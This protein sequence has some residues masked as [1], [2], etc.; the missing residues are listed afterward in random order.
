MVGYG[1]LTGY[2]SVSGFSWEAAL[3]F[4][5]FPF[6][7]PFFS[8]ILRK[9]KKRQDFS[10]QFGARAGGEGLV[11]LVAGGK[12]GIHYITY[13]PEGFLRFLFL[14]CFSCAGGFCTCM[15]VCMYVCTTAFFFLF[16]PFSL[17]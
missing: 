9:G 8:R 7:L 17:T 12:G 11:G 13:D 10:K 15:Y 16:L 2:H 1:F 4:F 3:I 14:F 6:F 5:S